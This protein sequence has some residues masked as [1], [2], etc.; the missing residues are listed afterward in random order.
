MACFIKDRKASIV[1]IIVFVVRAE[2]VVEKQRRRIVVRQAVQK[3][4]VLAKV[5]I[6]IQ[7]PA[8]FVLLLRL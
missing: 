6:S 7:R 5:Q 8:F 1:H 4:V 2:A 3:L